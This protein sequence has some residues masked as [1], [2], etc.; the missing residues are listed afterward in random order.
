MRGMRNMFLFLRGIGQGQGVVTLLLIPQHYFSYDGIFNADN[1]TWSKQ[2]KAMSIE[3]HS[4]R[5]RQLTAESLFELVHKRLIPVLEESQKNSLPLDLQDVLLR[6]TFDNVCMIAF[7]VDPRCL[8]L[9]LP[10][11]PFARAFVKAT[12]ATRELKESIAGV[13]K[14]AD[15]VIR[16]RKKELSLQ[17]ENSKE[18]SD[19]LTVF[20]RLK[21]E[22]G[23]PF[24]DKFLRD[25]GVNFIL[26]GRDT[27]SVALS[28]FFLAYQPAPKYRAEDST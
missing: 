25:I 20:M 2:R 6:M 14:F 8:G 19:L 16:T 27:S 22:K 11:I 26:A 10:K 24:S 18:R 15:E 21:D 13:N 1:E 4:A 17:C 12:E 9:G 7:G 23:Q 5:F 3:F 28:W